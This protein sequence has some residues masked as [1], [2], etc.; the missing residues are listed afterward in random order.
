MIAT[1]RRRKQ[2]QQEYQFS[3]SFLDIAQRGLRKYPD[4]YPN[5]IIRSGKI[6]YIDVEMLFDWINYREALEVKAPVPP[7]RREAYQ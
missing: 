1:R 6:V 7:F 4:R 5:A 2:L 3:P